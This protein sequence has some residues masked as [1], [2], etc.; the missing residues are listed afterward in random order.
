MSKSLASEFLEEFEV[1][2]DK[3]SHLKVTKEHDSIENIRTK[4]LPSV[5]KASRNIV[6][7]GDR[8]KPRSLAKLGGSRL[9]PPSKSGGSPDLR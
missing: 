1:S 8:N 5:K 4:R 6:N 9:T 3:C 7:D 2:D